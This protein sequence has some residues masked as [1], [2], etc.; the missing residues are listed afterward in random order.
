VAETQHNDFSIPSAAGSG[1]N[2]DLPAAAARTPARDY[3]FLLGI[4]GLVI[5][6][7]Q[8]TKTVVRANLG[9]GEIWTP[10][11]QISFLR[12]VHWHNTGAAFGLFRD[13]S[14]VF[15]ILAFVVSGAILYYFPR[16][17]REDWPLRLAMGLQLGG[18]IGNLIDRLLIGW[19][20]DFVSVG[21]FPVFNVADASISIGVAV[22]IAGVWLNDNPAGPQS[23]EGSEPAFDEQEPMEPPA[24][25]PM[26]GER[27]G[28]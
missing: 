17:P 24:A 13:F 4:A 9:V 5:T 14:L 12:I 3:L 15:T 25:G 22:L 1:E 11:P 2:E 6:L 18:A 23:P 7:D 27:T 28:D 19:V 26:H 21:T 10:F 8:L 16:V 20:T